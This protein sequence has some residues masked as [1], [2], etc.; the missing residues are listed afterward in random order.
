METL[1]ATAQQA[2]RKHG[3]NG[4]LQKQT[5][6]FEKSRFGLMALMLTAQSC[7]GGIAAMFIMEK[8]NFPHPDPFHVAQLCIVSMVTMGANAVMIAQA[9][10]K[11][12]VVSFYASNLISVAF[13]LLNLF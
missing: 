6:K 1:T 4:F 8:L 10:A 7:I 3:I 5:A 2:T 9:E 11:T 12:C 13:I